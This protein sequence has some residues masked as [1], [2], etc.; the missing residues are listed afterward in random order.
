MAIIFR[1]LRKNILSETWQTVSINRYTALQCQKAVAAYFTSKQILPYGFA[2]QYSWVHSKQYW[3]FRRNPPVLSQCNPR[4]TLQGYPGVA[5]WWYWRV[6][7][8]EPI[9]FRV[10]IYERLG[11]LMTLMPIIYVFPLILVILVSRQFSF[12]VVKHGW[13]NCFILQISVH[14]KWYM[15]VIQYYLT[16]YDYVY[17]MC[18]PLITQSKSE[19]IAYGWPTI[20][21]NKSSVHCFEKSV[22]GIL[23]PSFQWGHVSARSI[24]LTR[25]LIHLL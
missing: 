1:S 12:L 7:F 25:P 20:N 24:H 18:S 14:S 19:K 2:R 21:L 17:A 16:K 9:L 4:I 8:K 6:L 5:W 13:D 15:N 3:F 22:Y 23:I 11:I 10:Q